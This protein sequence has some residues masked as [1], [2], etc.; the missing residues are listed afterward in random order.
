MRTL[1]QQQPRSSF[2]KKVREMREAAGL[3][4]AEVSSLT[5][6][7][8]R[9]ISKYERGAQDMTVGR[10]EQILRVLGAHLEIRT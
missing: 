8:Q 6:I 4:Q 5:G 1:N 7:D 9:Q 3:S 10:L 2:G